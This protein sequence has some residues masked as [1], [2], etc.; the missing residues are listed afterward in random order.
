MMHL[1]TV[2]CSSS[3]RR[4]GPEDRIVDNA[5]EPYTTEG[6]VKLQVN[7]SLLQQLDNKK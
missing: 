4:A 1:Q 7:L 3:I 5:L 6:T 2:G